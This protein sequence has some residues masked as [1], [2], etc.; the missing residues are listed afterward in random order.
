MARFPLTLSFPDSANPGHFFANGTANGATLPQHYVNYLLLFKQLPDFD[1]NITGMLFGQGNVS[2]YLRKTGFIADLNGDA[3]IEQ[4]L[5]LC[6]AEDEKWARVASQ[7]ISG[8][9]TGHEQVIASANRAVA[10]VYDGVYIECIG[11]GH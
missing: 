9:V 11:Y 7:R 10:N 1:K 8:Q 6:R 3:E 4:G 5:H 2:I